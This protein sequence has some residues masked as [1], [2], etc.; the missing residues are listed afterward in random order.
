MKQKAYVLAIIFCTIFSC[1][2]IAQDCLE[3][4]EISGTDCVACVPDGWTF[5]G[6]TT[7]DI[8]TDDGTWP[9]GGCTIENLSGESP[10]GGNMSLFVSSNA[11]Y[12]EGMTTSVNGLNTNQEY[13]FGL[14]WEEVSIQN[15][16]IFTPGELIVIIDGEEYEFEGAEEWEFIQICFTPSQSTIEIELAINSEGANVIVVDSPNCNEVTPCCPLS[17]LLEEEEYEICPGEEF[18]IEGEIDNTEGDVIIEWI[19]KPENGIDFLSEADIISPTFNFPDDENFEGEVF[20]LTLTVED[21]NCI[22]E[23]TIIVTIRPSEVP[24]FEIFICELSFIDVFPTISLNGYTGSWSG[25]FD[26]EDLV[27]TVQEYTFTLD[28]GQDNCIQE[29]IYNIP[30]EEAI[31]ITFEYRNSYC[32]LDDEDYEFPDESEEDIEGE[33]DEDDFNPS[34]LGVG[35]FNFTF[36][37]Y[38]EFCAIPYIAEIEIFEESL[39]DFEIPDTFCVSDQDYVLPNSSLENIFGFWE[40]QSI[41]LSIPIQSETITFTPEDVNDCFQE[42][43]HTYSIVQSVNP[44][45]N[46]PDTICRLTNTVEFNSTSLEGFD[47]NWMPSTVNF[48]T[49]LSDQI[50]IE[51]T[52]KIAT[53]NCLVG[54]IKTIVITNT[55]Q[56]EVDLP[57]SLCRDNGIFTLPLSNSIDTLIGHW[58]INSFDPDTI[59]GASIDLIFTPNNDECVE[60]FESNVII[61]ENLNPV[62]DF[63]TTFCSTADEFTLPTIDVNGIVGT[64]S[65]PTIQPA[66]INGQVVSIFTANNSFVCYNL[67]EAT[68]TINNLITPIFDLPLAFCSNDLEYIFPD[69]S[70]NSIVGFWSEP[71]ISPNSYTQDSITNTFTPN[72]ISC[73]QTIEVMIP[74]I[75]LEK[76]Q[77][78]HIN[79]S[80]CSSNDGSIIFD[81]LLGFEIS[82]DNGIT[83]QSIPEFTNLGS[84][85]YEISVRHITNNNCL[86][87][88]NFQISAPSAPIILM[89]ET[90]DI[91]DCGKSDGSLIC[92]AEGNNLEFS[93][94]NGI[95]WQESNEFFDL[96]IGN[97]TVLV[98]SD[99]DSNCSTQQNFIISDIAD[100]ILEDVA[101]LDVSDCNLTNG[102]ILIL[103]DNEIYEYSLDQFNW[104]GSNTFTNLDEGNYDVFI[105]LKESTNCFDTK[106]I[107]ITSPIN[108]VIINLESESPSDCGINDGQIA[109][110]AIGNNLEYSIDNGNSWTTDN[111]FSNLSSGVFV[112]LARE[113]NAINCI[114]E[115]TITLETPNT[116]KIID[117]KIEQPSDCI[118]NNGSIEITTSISDVEFSIDNGN[119]WQAS[120]IFN[121]LVPNSY[122]VIIRNISSPDCTT[123]LSIDIVNIP[124]PCNDL[125]VKLSIVDINCFDANSGSLEITN[126]DGFFTSDDYQIL[127]STGSDESKIDNLSSGWYQYEI[128]YDKNCIFEDSVFLE[129]FDP[130]N[131]GLLGFDQNCE[132][133]GKI[134]VV[135]IQGGNGQFQFSLDG[136]NFQTD[137]VFFNLSADD[138]QVIVEDNFNCRQSQSTS[139]NADFDLSLDLPSIQPINSGEF[140]T[141]NPLINQSTIDSFEWSPAIGI[142][143][144]FNLI[145]QVSPDQTTEYTLTVYFGSCA[146]TRT[147]TVEVIENDRLYLGN[148]FSPNLDGNNDYF[149]IQSS[150][151]SNLEITEFKIYDR[152]GN[153]VYNNNNPEINNEKEGWDGTRNRQPLISGVYTYLIIYNK[154]ESKEILT[155]HVT[156]VK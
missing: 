14:Y 88:F 129:S 106:S 141:L 31:Q 148:T 80:S 55:K 12:Q 143:D 43:T 48:D 27:G 117:S 81:N 145:A 86:K 22:K 93:I 57:E 3:Y 75:N 2:I 36:Q 5:D 38:P 112:I 4:A 126:I 20:E 149:Y 116:P 69:S 33:W 26:F 115:S 146:E 99:G 103:P 51:W 35:V 114:D 62:F 95:T 144:P 138:Y 156:L 15:C 50:T 89:T 104:Q 19:S 140:T 100:V 137:N 82:I 78:S 17:L 49:I 47:G 60:P 45:F 130:I 11:N 79:A 56:I 84:G 67:Y 109:V 41:D 68:F 54:N 123:M 154:N 34:E 150:F 83:W 42:Y 73:N 21:D 52:P 1:K 151:Q 127:W 53:N 131:F 6:T 94:D 44:T 135:D 76:I 125:D 119:S 118:S 64:W 136:I 74:F 30:I 87:Q 40:V 122:S 28:P 147:V 96:S 9:G 24:E 85:N 132:E 25:D 153:L 63:Q 155:G 142:L 23:E 107:I 92:L 77:S 134:E 91:S 98:R 32:V 128:N 105:R 37:P 65:I 16:G 152:W 133:N 113:Q 121:N 10:G 124:C 70:I 101:I 46:I 90:M 97:Y 58:N 61:T 7:P 139:I 59:N 29:Y 13:G 72:D 66:S 111:N 8:I 102:E 110:E 71:V 39:L 18:I 120:G 108:P